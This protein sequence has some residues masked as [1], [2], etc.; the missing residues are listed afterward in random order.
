MGDRGVKEVGK[1]FKKWGGERGN[2]GEKRRVEW[3]FQL[4]QFFFGLGRAGL[5]GS[6]GLCGLS[7]GKEPK[8]PL[9]LLLPGG[10]GGGGGGL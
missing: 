9:L 4:I 3:D 1:G 2:K 8:E 6:L 10:K 7:V 5:G